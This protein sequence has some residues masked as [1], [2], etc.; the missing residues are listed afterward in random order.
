MKPNPIRQLLR[1]LKCRKRS[2]STFDMLWKIHDEECG[3]VAR[4][5][6]LNGWRIDHA[7]AATTVC[8]CV[9]LILSHS[10]SYEFPVVRCRCEQKSFY[11]WDFTACIVSRNVRPVLFYILFFF[12][13]DTKRWYIFSHVLCCCSHVC[14]SSATTTEN[15]IRK[16]LKS[17]MIERFS[18]CTACLHSCWMLSY[19]FSNFVLIIC[20]FPVQTLNTLTHHCV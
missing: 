13:F 10:H 14:M 2:T 18:L 4:V 9:C 11:L 16:R 19:H 20:C 17:D 5:S 3:C 1:H 6:L 12:S 8:V 7:T 15:R